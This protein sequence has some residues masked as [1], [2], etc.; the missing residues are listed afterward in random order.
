MA[1]VDN[2]NERVLGNNNLIVTSNIEKTK[3][4]NFTVNF[5]NDSTARCYIEDPISGVIYPILSS[6]AYTVTIGA[7]FLVHIYSL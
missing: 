2:P 3:R 7:R 1:K 4:V 6:S 5:I